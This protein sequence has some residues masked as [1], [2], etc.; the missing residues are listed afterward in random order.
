[1]E[2][3]QRARAGAVGRKSDGERADIAAG[4]GSY[5]GADPGQLDCHDGFIDRWNKRSGGRRLAGLF[6]RHAGHGRNKLTPALEARTWI[7][8]SAE[9]ADGST[10]WH[11]QA[12]SALSIPHMMVAR[13]GQCTAEASGSTITWLRTIRT[14]SA[15]RPT[16]LGCMSIRRRMRR[17]SAWTRRRRSSARPQGP[18][19]RCRRAGPSGTA[20]VLP[21]WHAVAVR[22][23]QHRNRRGAGQTAARHTSA[24]FVAF[25]ADIVVNQPAAKEIDVI[26]DNLSAH[27]TK[28]VTESW[29]GTPM[30]TCTSL[31]LTRPGSTSRLWFARSSATSSHARLHLRP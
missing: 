18:G 17:C 10:H 15:K 9:P 27:K 1:M 28:Q 21:T 26:A 25:L 16:L 22:S 14:S 13:Y 24:E 4:S 8:R 20:S 29:I 3:S 19:P 2:F 5:L 31:R 6:S 23:V 30:S 7:G 12:G 11:P